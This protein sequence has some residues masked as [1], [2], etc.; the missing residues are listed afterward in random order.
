MKKKKLLLFI[1]L[2]L[3]VVFS[4]DDTLKLNTDETGKISVGLKKEK[5]QNKQKEEKKKSND[6]KQKKEEKKIDFIEYSEDI[7]EAEKIN[8]Y[9]EENGNN[10]RYLIRRGKHLSENPSDL[11]YILENDSFWQLHLLMFPVPLS[12]LEIDILSPVNISLWNYI[13]GGFGL[14]KKDL[15]EIMHDVSVAPV[16]VN[17]QIPTLFSLRVWRIMFSISLNI[18]VNGSFNLNGDNTKNIKGIADVYNSGLSFGDKIEAG[19]NVNAFS[20]LKSSLGYGH[21]ITSSIG[22]FR[23]GGN[24]NIYFGT[25]MD[26]SSVIN[27]DNSIENLSG[28]AD[29]TINSPIS[30][31]D[32]NIFGGKRSDIFSSISPTF[33]IDLSFSYIPK[34]FDMLDIRV[35]FIDLFASVKL[36]KVYTTSFKAEFDT[37]NLDITSLISGDFSVDNLYTIKTNLGAE[38]KNKLFVISPKIKFA[39]LFNMDFLLANWLVE[40]IFYFYPVKEGLNNPQS[41]HFSVVNHFLFG[42]FQTHLGFSYNKNSFYLPFGLGFNSNNFEFLLGIS[43]YLGFTQG[44]SIKGAK[45]NLLMT[46]YFSRTTKK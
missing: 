40:S 41:I 45:L 6:S 29:L 16:Y 12:S 24:L 1:F 18:I 43:P 5:Q 39:P 42:I 11:N 23:V 21:S 2:S 34:S 9:F 8:F 7:A 36:N 37:A 14:S 25:G 44:F 35:A 33:G 3:Q 38:N 15:A 17:L 27:F 22:E 19:F 4:Q 31:K 10:Y 46:F 20:Y 13:T 26:A 28:N 32:N 30:S